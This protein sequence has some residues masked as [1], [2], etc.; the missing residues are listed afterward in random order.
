MFYCCII[1]Y[2]LF[3]MVRE[4]KCMVCAKMEQEGAGIFHG[5]CMFLMPPLPPPPPSS[6]SPSG[7]GI[8]SP[9]PSPLLLLLLLPLLSLSFSLSLEPWSCQL[10]RTLLSL[11]LFLNEILLNNVIII[12]FHYHYINCF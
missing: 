9:S 10:L 4:G 2:T 5:A 6:S 12:I 7:R 11:F 1:Y 8:L 3:V